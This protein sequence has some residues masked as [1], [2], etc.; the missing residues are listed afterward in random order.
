MQSGKVI[1][2]REN[3]MKQDHQTSFGRQVS[4]VLTKPDATQ[5]PDTLTDKWLLLTA[6]T[7]AAA[8]YGLNHRSLTVLRALLSFHPDRLITATPRSCIVFPANSTL[9]DRLAG[10]PE[11]TLRR[12]LAT[13]VKAGIVSRHDSANR[14]RFARGRAGEARIA[15]GFDLSPL[16]RMAGQITARAQAAQEHRA[17]AQ[18]LR[19]ELAALRQQAIQLHGETTDTNHAFKIL[20]R[21]PDLMALKACINQMKVILDTEEMSTTNSQNERHIQTES[22]IFTERTSTPKKSEPNN[23]PSFETVVSKCS[24]YLSFFPEPSQGWQ[25]LSRTAYALVPMMGIEQPVYA[26]A[27]HVVGARRAITVVLCMLETL[28]NI[29]NPGGYL[30]RLTQKDAEGH[31]DIDKLLRMALMRELSA[32]NS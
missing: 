6:L 22:K 25:D 7:E 9:S 3:V 28:G 8:D 14:K 27:I 26:Q 23:T 31:L 20:R 15:F 29:G 5:R 16:A 32:D 10:M 4:A 13:L 11:S 24:E 12:H 19:A 21:K 2:F 18:S 17:G 1:V 30:R